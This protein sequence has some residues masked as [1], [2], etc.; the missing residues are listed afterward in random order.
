MKS[1]F[2]YFLLYILIFGSQQIYFLLYINLILYIVYLPLVGTTKVVSSNPIHGEVYSIQY[3]VIKF[4]NDLR[5]D[6]GFSRLLRFPPPMKL[7]TT[8]F[9]WNI[10]ALSTM[11]LPPLIGFR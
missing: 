1:L 6:G 5:Q 10:V 3:Y 2:A 7:T 4:V 8:I 11:T 9:N